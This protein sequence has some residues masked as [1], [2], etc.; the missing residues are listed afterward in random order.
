MNSQEQS[1]GYQVQLNFAAQSYQFHDLDLAMAVEQLPQRD[2]DIVV[3]HLMGHTQNAIAEVFSL[4]R[5]M[6]SKRLTAITDN[7]KGQLNPN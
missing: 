5:S 4:S 3:L 7:L 1:T 2:K 6:I